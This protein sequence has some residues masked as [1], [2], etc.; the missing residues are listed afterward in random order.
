MVER[1]RS[2][3]GLRGL[4][5]AAEPVSLRSL[6]AARKQAGFELKSD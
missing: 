1:K 5:R 4:V 2:L 6:G 3:R